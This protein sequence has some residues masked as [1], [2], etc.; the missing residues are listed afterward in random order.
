MEEVNRILLTQTDLS[1]YPEY[2]RT[3][4]KVVLN[5]LKCQPEANFRAKLKFIYWVN[6]TI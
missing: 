1:F 5:W 2:S 3:I 6:Y 4:R